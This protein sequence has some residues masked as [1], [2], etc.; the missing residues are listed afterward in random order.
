[1]Y[2]AAHSGKTPPKHPAMK[3]PTAMPGASAEKRFGKT[4]C[5]ATIIGGVGAH[6]FATDRP[7]GI[8]LVDGRSSVSPPV[9]ATYRPAQDP[10]EF[11]GSQSLGRHL[12]EDPLA[13]DLDRQLRVRRV[14]A[15]PRPIA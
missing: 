5:C 7:A 6:G 8:S 11:W 12:R 2:Q 10:R 1:M 14:P 9:L 15:P 13:L 4:R 3:P